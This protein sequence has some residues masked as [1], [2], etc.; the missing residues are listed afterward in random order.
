[1][2]D[3]FYSLGLPDRLMGYLLAQQEVDSRGAAAL[4]AVLNN[5][6]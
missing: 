1:M 6:L 2:S 3:T 5:Y 4:R